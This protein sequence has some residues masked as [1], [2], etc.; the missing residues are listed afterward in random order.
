M[1]RSNRSGR[2]CAF[3]PEAYRRLTRQMLARFG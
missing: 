2:D 3:K 1:S